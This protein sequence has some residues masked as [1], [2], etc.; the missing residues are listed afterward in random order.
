MWRA[1][2]EWE[3]C[4]YC[5]SRHSALA[6]NASRDAEGLYGEIYSEGVRE[7]RCLRQSWA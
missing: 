3:V 6:A 2:Y 1:G 4:E 7:R 5:L